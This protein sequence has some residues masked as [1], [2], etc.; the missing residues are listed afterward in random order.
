MCVQDTNIL[1]VQTPTPTHTPSVSITPPAFVCVCTYMTQALLK[2]QTHTHTHLQCPLQWHKSSVSIPHPRSFHLP[3]WF[4]QKNSSNPVPNT[5]SPY[6]QWIRSDQVSTPSVGR[7]LTYYR[8]LTYTAI[9]LKTFDSQRRKFQNLLNS[10]RFVLLC[11]IT[12]L[13]SFTPQVFNTRCGFN[14]DAG[15]ET[16]NLPLILTART[17]S[18]QQNCC[19]NGPT[20]LFSNKSSL[21][22][23]AAPTHND[24]PT[25]TPG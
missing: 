1:K 16:T 21:S 17:L 6:T 8:P 9:T 25:H 5:E 20:L 19:R 12:R 4:A 14:K 22:R 10:S 7:P 2:V 11:L 18:V 24:M 23:S 15:L 3:F 13:T